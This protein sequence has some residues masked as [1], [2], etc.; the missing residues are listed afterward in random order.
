MTTKKHGEHALY[1][2]KNM[3]ATCKTLK[4]TKKAAKTSKN[5]S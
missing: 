2:Q 5:V 1:K 4:I 3:T